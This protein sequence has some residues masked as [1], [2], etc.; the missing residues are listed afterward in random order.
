MAGA[1]LAPFLYSLYG[2]WVT[3]ASVWAN[4][5]FGAGIMILN[6]II[7]PSFPVILQ[8]PINSGVIAMLA[9]F[10]IVPLVSA[11]TKKPDKDF[12]D[13]CFECYEKKVLVSQKVSMSD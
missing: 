11:F 6:M 4:F 5:I 1:F 9:G 10:I 13:G 2:K 8:S 12:V 7:R 3:K